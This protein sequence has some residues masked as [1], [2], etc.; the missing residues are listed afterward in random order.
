MP[1]AGV[2]ALPAF[3]FPF[4]PVLVVVAVE[5]EALAVLFEAETTAVLLDAL[6]ILSQYLKSIH[7]K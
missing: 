1:F 6:K 5:L 3:P 4:F 7:K 2:T